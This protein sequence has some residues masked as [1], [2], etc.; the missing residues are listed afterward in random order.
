MFFIPGWVIAAA[1]FPGV[2]LHEWAH[3]F[4]CDRTG[5]PV[6]EV[7]YFNFGDDVGG[8]VRHGEPSSF[9]QSFYISLGPLFVNSVATIVVAYA[10]TQALSGSPLRWL[11]LWLSV[12]VGM[13][14]FPSNHDARCVVAAARSARAHGASSLYLLTLP[15]VLLVFIANPLRMFW[16]DLAYAVLLVFAGHAIAGVAL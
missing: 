4:F 9:W 7:C 10:S 2:V 5:V 16:F 6:Y 11:L 1:T 15:L 8:F 13:H 3:K 12:S 14:A